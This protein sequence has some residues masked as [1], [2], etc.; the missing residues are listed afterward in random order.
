MMLLMVGNDMNDHQTAQMQVCESRFV[1]SCAAVETFR[2]C[3]LA[4]ASHV[5][6][7]RR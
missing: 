3:R 4:P 1:P 2:N 5:S 7:H 6:Q